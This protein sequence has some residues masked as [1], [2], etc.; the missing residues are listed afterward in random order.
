MRMLGRYPLALAIAMVAH[1]ANRAFCRTIGDEAQQP[2]DE[3]PQWQRDSACNGVIFHLENPES[4]PADSHANWMAEKEAAGWGYGEA[5]DAEARTHPC[6]VPYE[7]LPEEQRLK[8][9][10][11][12]SIV[13][14]LAQEAQPTG[15]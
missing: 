8:D 13:R 7:Q 14:A 12:L 10:L 2:W 15:V 11:F 9:A 1:E 5:K 4:T 6:M 3:A